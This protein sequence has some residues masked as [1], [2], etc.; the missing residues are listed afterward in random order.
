M[1]FGEYA[2]AKSLNKLSRRG[3]TLN[4]EWPRIEEELCN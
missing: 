3:K 1:P 4:W 2:S